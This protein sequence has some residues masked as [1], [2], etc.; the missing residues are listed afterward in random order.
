[1]DRGKRTFKQ[2]RNF[3]DRVRDAENIR[4]LHP[5]KIPVIIERYNGEKQLPLLDKIKFLIPSHL[6]VGELVKLIRRKMS[7]TPNQVFFLLVNQRY[8]A[9]VSTVLAE[10]YEREKDDDGFL[11]IVYASEEGFGGN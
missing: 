5:T 4:R 1:M 6:T 11:Y 2:K 8:L 10:L 9:S 3:H 7:L